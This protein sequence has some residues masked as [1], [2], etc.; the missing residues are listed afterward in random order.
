MPAYLLIPRRDSLPQPLNQ[1]GLLLHQIYL[2]TWITRQIREVQ[3]D[4]FQ[5]IPAPP[6]PIIDVILSTVQN[7][8]PVSFTNSQL[9]RTILPED[10][11]VRLMLFTS[12]KSKNTLAVDLVPWQR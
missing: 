12:Y 3:I 8:F 2:L 10:S 1:F 7:M 4:H 5:T 9:I 6:I 11:I